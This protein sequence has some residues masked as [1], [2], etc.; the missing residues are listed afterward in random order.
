MN[1]AAACGTCGTCH[2][3]EFSNVMR[4]PN[5]D[6]LRNGVCMVNPPIPVMTAMQA[7]GSSL[8]PGGPQL[9]PAVQGMLPPITENGRCSKWTAFNTF[10]ERHDAN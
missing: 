9:M 1:D 5:G 10:P 4:A 3:W 8:R 6:E 7:P 2:W